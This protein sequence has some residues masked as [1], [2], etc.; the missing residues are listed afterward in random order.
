[1]MCECLENVCCMHVCVSFLLVS[2]KVAPQ[3]VTLSVATVNV[4]SMRSVSRAQSVLAFLGG[5]QAD[6]ICLQECWLPFRRSYRP[7]E[8]RWPHGPSLWSGSDEIIS[9]TVSLF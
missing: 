6:I 4:R 5:V 9:A 8:K 7:W 2:L 1:M 3:H